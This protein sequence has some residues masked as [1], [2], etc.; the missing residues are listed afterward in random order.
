MDKA[1]PTKNVFSL[2]ASNELIPDL[3]EIDKTLK[4]CQQKLDI[5][6]EGKRGQFP[7]FYF[8]SNSVLLDI[9]SKRSDP[10]NIKSNLNIIF[11]AINDIDF[12]EVDKKS[13]VKIKQ[14]KN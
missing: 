2:C 8:V 13:I 4:E 12:N 14:I 6:L 9:L 1:F 10:S 5:Y 11:D 7:R 3:S